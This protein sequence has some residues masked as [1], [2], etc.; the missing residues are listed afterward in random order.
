MMTRASDEKSIS[1]SEIKDGVF[2]GQGTQTWPEG[3]KFIGLYKNDQRNG[4]GTLTTSDEEVFSG[5]CGDGN[6]ADSQ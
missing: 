1:I 3:H 5:L 4:W 2:K 6:F